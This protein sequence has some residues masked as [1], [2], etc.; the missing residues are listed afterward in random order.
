MND[1]SSF[2][3]VMISGASNP[4]EFAPGTEV[5][6]IATD[7]PARGLYFENWSPGVRAAGGNIFNPTTT[8]IMPENNLNLIANFGDGT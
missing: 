6:I 2:I 3:S 5:T 8:I 7:R 4:S 1:D